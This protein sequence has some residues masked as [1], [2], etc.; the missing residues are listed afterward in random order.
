[1]PNV[2]SLRDMRQL[3]LL[4]QH[5]DE[6]KTD[7]EN[8]LKEYITEYS[9]KGT[10]IEMDRLIASAIMQEN[11]DAIDS[12]LVAECVSA[13]T[14]LSIRIHIARRLFSVRNHLKLW[15]AYI[16][17]VKQLNAELSES[18]RIQNLKGLTAGYAHLGNE[19]LYK[20]WDLKRLINAT[21]ELQ[22][23]SV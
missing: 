16:D 12:F 23:A 11:W 10:K 17:I 22:A 19:A 3:K 9:L 1:M 4:N 7:L 20:H 21:K 13:D 6:I 14:D 8:R 18:E 5:F 2:T 15:S